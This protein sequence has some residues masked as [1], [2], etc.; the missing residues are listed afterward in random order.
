MQRSEHALGARELLA[1]SCLHTRTAHTFYNERILEFSDATIR[2]TATSLVIESENSGRSNL[3]SAKRRRASQIR[4][5]EKPDTDGLAT[6]CPF[7]VYP[8]SL[9]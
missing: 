3:G 5:N 8:S 9:G 7:R 2:P 6:R 1:S 4:T